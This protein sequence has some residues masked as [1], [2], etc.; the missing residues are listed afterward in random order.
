MKINQNMEFCLIKRDFMHQQN[1]DYKLY[2]R[3]EHE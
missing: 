3:E 2:W 1:I